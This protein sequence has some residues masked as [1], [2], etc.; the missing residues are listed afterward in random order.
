M[1]TYTDTDSKYYSYYTVRQDPGKA[2]NSKL[3]F[4]T[5]R[6]PG[7]FR[8]E[9]KTVLG[10]AQASRVEA[11]QGF[12]WS[13]FIQPNKQTNKQTICTPSP[14]L[15][16]QHNRNNTYYLS[17]CMCTYMYPCVRWLVDRQ[18]VFTNHQISVLSSECPHRHSLNYQA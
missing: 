8:A 1:C 15:G 12:Y 10:K 9:S 18:F 16:I 17:L 11:S 2:Y 6:S 14:D 7:S 3:F 13:G 5:S 4:C